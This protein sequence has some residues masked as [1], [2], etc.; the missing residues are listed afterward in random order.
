[1]GKLLLQGAP[2]EFTPTPVVVTQE[3]VPKGSSHLG[4]VSD[5]EQIPLASKIRPVNLGTNSHGEAVLVSWVCTEVA[6]LQLQ[7]VEV[8]DRC[9]SEKTQ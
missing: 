2:F 3:P 9:A 4:K 8:G 1:M 5:R 6:P 7:G